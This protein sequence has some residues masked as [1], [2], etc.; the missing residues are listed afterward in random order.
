MTQPNVLNGPR[1]AD[2]HSTLLIASP[3]LSDGK[4]LTLTERPLMM[5]N[6]FG[7]VDVIDVVALECKQKGDIKDFLAALKEEWETLEETP[8]TKNVKDFCTRMLQEIASGTYEHEVPK[9]L[10]EV[11]ERDL[12]PT[13]RRE[14]L[15]YLSGVT[16]I[17]N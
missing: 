9:Y 14:Q 5:P 8:I 2:L 13:L 4:F 15:M 7:G 17:E 12:R 1:R 10:M 6:A 3:E 16:R 11:I